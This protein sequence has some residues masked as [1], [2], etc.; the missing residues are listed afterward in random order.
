MRACP[1]F[2][3]AA[4]S[5]VAI[6]AHTLRIVPT[7]SVRTVVDLPLVRELAIRSFVTSNL[8]TWDRVRVFLLLFGSWSLFNCTFN[9][10][11]VLFLV[12]LIR[13]GFMP[14]LGGACNVSN[15]DMTHDKLV[16]SHNN[17]LWRLGVK[18]N[19]C[20]ISRLDL[21]RRNYILFVKLSHF[22]D[23]TRQQFFV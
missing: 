6:Y 15:G 22:F 12:H 14:W 11:W 1:C 5:V 21:V 20:Y 2:L 19:I 17:L 7:I 3:C 9:E 23:A 4:T 13:C 16:G 18:W 10:I 8:A